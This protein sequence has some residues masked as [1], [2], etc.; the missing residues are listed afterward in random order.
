VELY[1]NRKLKLAPL[2]KLKSFFL[3]GPRATGKSSLIAHQLQGKC[4][5]IDLLKGDVYFRL[6]AQPWLLENMILSADK[7]TI[8]VIDEI[9]RIPELLN[10]VHRLIEEKHYRFLLT[11]SSARKL[12]H[13]GVNLLA[14]R[15]W[16]A[17]L[18]PLTYQE[19]PEFDLTRYLTVGGIPSIYLSEFPQEELGAY[20]DTYLKE[21]IQA[22]AFVRKMGAFSRFL[23]VCSLT[24]GQMIN[25]SSISSDTGV[26]VSTVREYYQLIEDT[27]L[28][29]T[30]PVWTKSVKRK[31]IATA[32]F[33]L[34]DIGVKNMLANINQLDPLSNLFGDAFE[35]FIALELRAYLKY[36]R[37]RKQLAYWRTQNGQ[38]VDFVIGDDVAIEVKATTTVSSKHL[39]GLKALQEEGLCKHYLL[40]S[41]DTLSQQ[42]GQIQ[43]MHWQLFLEKLWNDA[44]E[45]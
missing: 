43:I 29:F 10:E 13:E 23:Q 5:V 17:H 39:K 8:I 20:V 2:L 41:Q 45:L 15:A 40:V 25:F 27:L 11:G 28:G 30:V 19:I 16:E 3:F 24:S 6:S 26:P 1:L 31:P 14:G 22:E 42:D 44:F 18:C 34:F 9:Q 7:E 36:K 33:Y 38:E 4:K 37:I 32:K 35:H 12:R 21:E